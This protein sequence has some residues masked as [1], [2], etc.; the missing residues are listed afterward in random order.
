MI[1]PCTAIL[2]VHRDTP[3]LWSS[4][5]ALKWCEHIMVVDNDSKIDVARLYDAGVTSVFAIPG[6]IDTDGKSTDC[7]HVSETK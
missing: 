1:A 3:V 7:R 2:L 6:S 4:L 5:S